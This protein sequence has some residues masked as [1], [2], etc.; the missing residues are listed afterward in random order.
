MSFIRNNVLFVLFIAA[1]IFS[2]FF[3]IDIFYI[4]SSSME[5]SLFKGDYILVSKVNTFMTKDFDIKRGD[6]IVFK[7]NNDKSFFPKYIIKRVIGISGDN[8]SYG[9]KTLFIND[10]EILNDDINQSG[11]IIT[12]TEHLI[13]RNHKIQLDNTVNRDNDSASVYIGNN[14]FFVMGDNRDNSMDSRFIGV[15]DKNNVVGKY[16]MTLVN[17]RNI[18]KDLL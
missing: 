15:V 4:P 9:N 2:K 13:D 11:N 7:E 5:P 1:F 6:I 3:L 14:E 10:K 16:D 8:I 18:F 17:F 12:K